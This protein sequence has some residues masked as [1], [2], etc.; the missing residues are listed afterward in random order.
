MSAWPPEPCDG[1]Q[2]SAWQATVHPGWQL[3][4]WRTSARA[5]LAADIAPEAI[6]WLAEGVGGLLPLPELREAPAQRV[7]PPVPSRLMEL[8]ATV[9]C[10]RDPHRHA[11]LYR[12]A[13]RI[14]H[15]ERTLLEIATDADVHRAHALAQ[16]V[17]RDTHKMKAFVRFRSL[18]LDAE[19]DTDANTCADAPEAARF[20]ERFIAWYQPEHFILERIAPFFRDRFRGMHWTIV[21]PEG[22]VTWDGH[23]LRLGPGGQRSDVPDADAGEALWRTYY[24]HIFNPARLNPDRMRQEMPQKFWRNLPEAAELPGMIREAGQRVAQMH[25]RQPQ[26]PRRRIP[27]RR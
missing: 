3:D 6:H 13:W 14:L 5:G 18:R 27:G 8:A 16:A 23:A 20:D 15:G 1:A 2:A 12:L 10:H 9:L 26:P 24:R 7:L 25:A 21:T 19:Q 11:L 4:A 22:R 17:R